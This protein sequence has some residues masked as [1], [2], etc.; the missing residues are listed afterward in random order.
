MANVP[1]RRRLRNRGAGTEEG[2]WEV[3]VLS[4]QRRRPS[5][6]SAPQTALPGMPF[7]EPLLSSRERTA[8]D[9]SRPFPSSAPRPSPEDH[10]E[11]RVRV[12]S[13]HLHRAE[14]RGDASSASVKSKK[15]H[16]RRGERQ[17]TSK[18]NTRINNSISS[19]SSS[20][21]GQLKP[22]VKSS[23]HVNKAARVSDSRERRG[24]SKTILIPK[25][26]VT[27]ASTET[28]H[29]LSPED[30]VQKTIKDQTDYG[31]YYRHRSPSTVEAYT[32][33]KP[34]GPKQKP[35]L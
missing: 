9:S 12:R 14:A 15:S 29:S 7:L 26:V 21:D 35:F 2:N 30:D 28:V 22:S 10:S 24:E 13:A 1:K 8:R 4:D 11:P 5:R 33:N 32:K 16:D 23:R 19:A 17:S 6:P 25:I 20:Y 3:R 31:P 27:R 18:T 34:D